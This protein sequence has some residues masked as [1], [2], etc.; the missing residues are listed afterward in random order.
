MCPAPPLAPAV[1]EDLLARYGEPHRHYHN[2]RHLAEVLEVVDEFADHATDVEAVRLAAWFHDAVYDPQRIDNEQASARLAART[3]M[4]FGWPDERTREVVRLVLLTTRHD[5]PPGD[6]NGALLCD[7]DLRILGAGPARYAAYRAG[8]RLEYA[9]LDDASYVVGRQ[10]VL[11]SLLALPVLY[12]L[13]PARARWEER[14]RRNVTAELR[15]LEDELQHQ[16]GA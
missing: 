16:A 2:R 6:R 14:A 4:E 3:L 5:A 9:H 12:R 15:D 7:A 1:F 10:A 8:V 13:A 11:R